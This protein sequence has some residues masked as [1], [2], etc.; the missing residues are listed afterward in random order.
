MSL[1][2]VYSVTYTK[3]TKDNVY[4]FKHV[5][6]IKNY[7]GDTITV[8]LPGHHPLFGKNISIRVAGIDTPEIKGKTECEKDKAKQARDLVKKY[9]K[10]SKITLKN[11]IRGKYFRIVADVYVNK[12]LLSKKLI[13]AKLA[14]PYDGG[15]KTKHDWCK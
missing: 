13:D 15:T 4:S 3:T 2:F 14:I 7:D 12:E 1:V 5:K 8:D 10:S 11:C 6:Y 9:L